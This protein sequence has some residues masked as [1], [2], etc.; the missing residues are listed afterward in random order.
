M[1]IFKL[2]NIP[3]NY[4]WGIIISLLTGLLTSIAFISVRPTS[5][6]VEKMI[7]QESNII[8]NKIKYESKILQT[9]MD[10]YHK[11]GLSVRDLLDTT[12]NIK[13]PSGEEK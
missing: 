8:Q 9:Q 13:Y 6:S 1:E 4:L 7:K 11:S 10:I 12:N 2:K 5:N 3:I